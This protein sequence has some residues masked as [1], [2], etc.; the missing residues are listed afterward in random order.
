MPRLDIDRQLE[1]EPKRMDYAIGKIQEKGY[2][3]SKVSDTEI[4]FEFMGHDVRFFPY[5]GWASGSMIK[6]G[7]GIIKLLRQI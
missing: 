6:D 2:E 1:L 5:S 4:Q 7:R 3:V